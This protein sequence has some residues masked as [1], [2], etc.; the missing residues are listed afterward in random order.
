MWKLITPKERFTF[1]GYMGRKPRSVGP[2]RFIINSLEICHAD[3][4]NIIV[5]SAIN[6]LSTFANDTNLTVEMHL[7]HIAVLIAITVV[8]PLLLTRTL[9]K[10]QWKVGY[11]NE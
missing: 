2:I 10:N 1:N 9:P 3:T 4:N 11:K 5:H 7:L 8:Y 6:T